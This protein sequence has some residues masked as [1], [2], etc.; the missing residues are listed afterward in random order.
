MRLDLLAQWFVVL[1][2]MVFQTMMTCAALLLFVAQLCLA[3]LKPLRNMT[4]ALLLLQAESIA[5]L[6]E[7]DDNQ[8]EEQEEGMSITRMYD[9]VC[10]RVNCRHSGLWVCGSIVLAVTQKPALLHLLAMVRPLVNAYVNT[11]CQRAL[12]YFHWTRIMLCPGRDTSR[13]EQKN[14]ETVV[15]QQLCDGFDR[16]DALSLVVSESDCCVKRE[17]TVASESS[18]RRNAMHLNDLSCVVRSKLVCVSD[19]ASF[20]ATPIGELFVKKRV[21]LGDISLKLYIFPN[22][23]TS[24]QDGFVQLV[25]ELIGLPAHTKSVIVWLHLQCVETRTHYKAIKRLSNLGDSDGWT[26]SLAT[27]QCASMPCLLFKSDLALLQTEEMMGGK[28]IYSRAAR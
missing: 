24:T 18:C 26:W 20:C 22:G 16:G 15:Q 3:I 25:V 2:W 28:P 8:D 7:P 9:L 27:Q 1:S 21:S 13:A 12:F 23:M 6:P 19:V 10:E 5:A 4:C 11:H 14:K 17:L